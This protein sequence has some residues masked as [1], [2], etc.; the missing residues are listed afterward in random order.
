[1]MDGK[2][3]LHIRIK[4]FRKNKR[5][6]QKQVA[7]YL[8]VEIS[9][10]AH[11][12]KG[13]RTPSAK[14][15]AKLAE[16]Y[17]LNDE[18]LGVTMPLET[19]VKYRTED[20]ELLKEVLDS[21]SWIKNDCNHN[22]RQYNQLIKAA[23]PLLK[24]REEALSL[25]LIDVDKLNNGNDVINVKLDILGEILIEKYLVELQHFFECIYS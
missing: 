19:F 20:I 16:L 2:K 15:L 5:M 6:T 25:T 8:G 14:K 1:M 4:E 22:I 18:M 9:T 21:C 3:E 10:Y 7:D 13:D 12:E 24:S 11:Y 17:E 23:N